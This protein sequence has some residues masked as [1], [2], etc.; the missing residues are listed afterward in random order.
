MAALIETSSIFAAAR[1]CR[2]SVSTVR[3]WLADDKFQEEYQRHLRALV[4]DTVSALRQ[5]GPKAVKALLAKLEEKNAKASDVI[6][7]ARV[8]LDNM[9]K[10]A[11][12]SDKENAARDLVLDLIT[13]AHE[14]NVGELRRKK[15]ALA[16]KAAKGD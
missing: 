1:K 14:K 12:P 15:L 7:A 9:V 5:S 13:S 8:L 16:K 6:A 2:Y 4:D 11:V 10:M 3:R